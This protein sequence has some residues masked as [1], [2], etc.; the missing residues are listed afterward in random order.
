M[1]CVKESHEKKK[2][3]VGQST[4]DVQSAFTSNKFQYV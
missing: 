4:I 3:N 1:K 2:Q